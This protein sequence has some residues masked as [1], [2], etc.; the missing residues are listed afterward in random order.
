MHIDADSK[1]AP[2]Y[3]TIIKPPAIVTE[4]FHSV[5]VNYFPEPV[6]SERVK[7]VPRLLLLLKPY[8]PI[9]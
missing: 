8:F 1:L 5:T 7:F 4:H 3:K 2:L 9:K 6:A